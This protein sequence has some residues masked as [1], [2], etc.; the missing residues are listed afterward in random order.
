ML[1]VS[2]DFL[3]PVSCVTNVTSVSGMSLSCILCDQCYQCLWIFFVLCRVWPMLRVSGV[4]VLC[5]LWPMLPVSLDCL[6]PV[7]CVTNV[8][9]VSGFP[10]SRVL[11]DQCYV[12]LESL[13]CVFCDQCYQFLWFFFVLCL[14]WPMLR[15][16]GVFVIGH[17]RQDK[18]NPDTLV[19]LV[20]EETGQR[21]Q[22]HVTLVTQDTGQRKSRDT[23]NIWSH[24]T[25]DKDY[26]ETL[27]TLVT[28]DTVQRQSRDTSNS[29][30]TRHSTKIIQRQW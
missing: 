15:V 12:S 13:S 7:S 18:E 19:T 25:Q 30:H 4:F 24:K 1:P 21:L 3:C 16:S 22:R 26:P 23:G 10:L 14:V 8:T 29:G 11:C 28:H 27:V 17:T 9:S 5:L 2:L 6:C 20:T